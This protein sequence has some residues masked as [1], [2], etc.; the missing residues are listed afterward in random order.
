MQIS[1]VMSKGII[2]VNIDDTIK[3]VSE[4]MRDK[5]I[6]AVPVFEQEKPVGFVTDRDLVVSG[7]AEGLSFEEPVSRAMSDSVICIEA[8]KE[9]EEASR[10]M[11][12]RQVSRLLV[13][14]EN[15]KPVG[16]LSLQNLSETGDEEVESET[17]TGIK[18]S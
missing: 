5:D 12:E 10:L 7:I 2:G 16:M 11:Q 15:R 18:E 14:D 9:V 3:K 13:I 17:L 6:G 4:L 1:E 8:D